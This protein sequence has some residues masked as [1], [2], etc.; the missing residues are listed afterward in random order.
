MAKRPIHRKKYG[1]SYKVHKIRK[2]SRLISRRKGKGVIQDVA[3]W[4]KNL[5]LK[6]PA[7]ST[8]SAPPPRY[9]APPPPPRSSAPPPPPPP[10]QSFQNMSCNMLWSKYHPG[11]PET[12]SAYKRW[13]LNTHPDKGGDPVLYKKA[14]D[15]Y[16]SYRSANPS[17]GGSFRL[18]L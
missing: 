14:Y 16:Q 6:K 1:G 18:A 8:N 2:R 15:C 9:S 5:F 3:N 7:Q 17:G 13:F 12:S 4:F 11:Q 10:Q